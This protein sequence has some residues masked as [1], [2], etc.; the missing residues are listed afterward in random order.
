MESMKSENWDMI[1][2]FFVN[3]FKRIDTD[4]IST[5]PTT[6]ISVLVGITVRLYELIEISNFSPDKWIN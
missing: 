6:I 5:F 3:L 1:L 2:V 4:R